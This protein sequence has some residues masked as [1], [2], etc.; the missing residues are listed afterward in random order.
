MSVWWKTKNKPEES[1]RHSDAD[2]TT[3]SLN[4]ND[5]LI[6][7][8]RL[9]MKQERSAEVNKAV[10]EARRQGTYFRTK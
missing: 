4:E 9:K 5:V 7:H 2:E 8:K 1:L 6:L 3:V 10:L